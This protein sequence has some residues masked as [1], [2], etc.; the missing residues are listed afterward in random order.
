MPDTLLTTSQVELRTLR[1]SDRDDVIALNGDP[2]V[3]RFIGAPFT[4]E[5]ASA[6][7]DE[8]LAAGTESTGLGWWAVIERASGAFAGLVALKRLSDG[9]HAALGPLVAGARD[10]E[11]MEIGWRFRPRFWG[12]GI[13]SETGRA[14]VGRA[15]E[16][17]GFPRIC[18]VALADNKASCRAIEKCGLRFEANYDIAGKRASFFVLTREEYLA[19]GR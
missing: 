17:H 7:L 12:R 14:L 1:P 13:A 11:L 8:I 4:A 9:N 19:A 18:A 3:M 6:W 2:E 15:F 16:A 5:R 10:D